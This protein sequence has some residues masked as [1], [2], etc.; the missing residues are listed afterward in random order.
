MNKRGSAV[1]VVLIVV[2][3]L[4]IVGGVW[5]YEVQQSHSPVVS[6]NSVTNSSSQT[7]DTSGWQTY[8]NAMYGYT[9]SYPP[10][11]TIQ[12]DTL[13]QSNDSPGG[14]QLS[15]AD[16]PA[17]ANDILISINT[18]TYPDVLTNA[19]VSI[20]PSEF[21]VGATGVGIGDNIVSSTFLLDGSIYTANGV[22]GSAD[23]GSM[24][25]DAQV[26]K[27][28]I[29]YTFSPT[30]LKAIGEPEFSEVQNE[31]LAII[32]TFGLDK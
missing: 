24:F 6:V 8:H 15:P 23:D 16:S 19:S 2:I 29:G 21:Y 9:I 22:D 32:K 20:S 30:D 3:I 25:M 12:Y 26:G 28:E 4:L 14:M 18:S 11:A 7:I 10:D 1:V 5:Y 27:V 13:Q 17:E 31:L